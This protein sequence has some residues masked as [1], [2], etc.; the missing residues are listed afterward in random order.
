MLYPPSSL[1]L[2]A[3]AQTLRRLAQSHERELTRE[4]ADALEKT[5][6]VVVYHSQQ[7]L[8]DPT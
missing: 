5:I 3:A 4:E 1:Q 7:A 6:A 2:A 8:D